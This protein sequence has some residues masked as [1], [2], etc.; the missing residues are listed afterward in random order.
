MP[1]IDGVV[2]DVWS[3][4]TE[5]SI[6][7]TVAGS[8]PSSPADCS[9]TWRGLWN[10]EYMY[11]LVVVN[12][13]TLN[14]D[15]GAGTK[16]EDDSVEFYIDGDNSKAA[17][18]DENDHQYTFRWN[19]ATVEA[20]SAIHNG[21]PSLA[22]VEYVMATTDNGYIF[23]VR[24]PWTSIMA[25][26][27][28][29][30]PV[31]GIEVWINDDDD[32]GG[33]DSQLSWYGTSGDGWNTPS[34]W[35]TGLLVAGNKATNPTPA[36]GALHPDIY[37]SL[38]WLP[39]LSA[40][41]HNVYFGDNFDDVD[42]GTGGTF[43][44]NTENEYLIVGFVGYPHPE[45]LVPDTTYYWRVD[46]VN[47][48]DPNSPW[49]GDVWSFSIPPK[50]AYFP[51]PAD[52][53][54]F[55]DADVTLTWEP[56]FGARTHTVYFGDDFDTV[57]NA[58]GGTGIG[59]TEY[60]PGTLERE[61]V[62]Y[63]RV[64]ETDLFETH[65]GDVW[66]FRT[67]KA[68]GGVRGD[69]YSGMDFRTH[70]LTRIDPQINFNWGTGEPDP[71]VGPD[72][73]SVR[74]TGE[75]EAGYTE[76]YTFYTRVDDGVR[77]WVGG[78]QLVG[79]EAWTDQGATEYSG[80][81]DLVAQNT[82]SITMEYYENGGDAVAELRWS[83][84]ST[85]KQFIPQ[86]AFSPPVR[87]SGPSPRNGA[88]DAKM[89]PTLRWNPGD[90]AASHEVYFGTDQ[91]AVKNATTGSPEYK[92]TRTLGDESFEPGKLAW[93]STYYWRVDEVNNLHADSPWVGNVW[94]FKT[95][96]FLVV[97][98][99]EDYDVDNQI[100]WNWLDGLGY[101]D[102][103][104]VTHAGNGSGSEAGDPDTA[105]YTEETIRH[106]GSQSMPYWYNNSGST[107]KF[108][109][110]EA[111][112]TLTDT[113]D[114][115]EE[116]V[117]ALSLW[118]RGYPASVGSLVESP[119]GT[120]AMTGSGTDIAGQSD[121][122]HYAYKVLTGPGTIV[123]RVDSVENTNDW[124]KAGVMIRET[125]EA[126]SAHAF[127]F[128]TPGNGTVFEYRP[129]AGQNYVPNAGQVTGVT[130]PYWVRL[131]RDLAGNFT[132]SA[133]T[134]GS[135]WQGL[136]TAA[137]IQMSSN[138]YIGLALTSHDVALTCQAVFSNVTISGN[139]SGQWM[140]Q[141]IGIQ[142]NDPEPMYVAVANSTG[143]PAVVYHDNPNA[144]QADTW[145]EW[146][147]DLKEFQ[148]KGINLTDVDSIAIGF[149][150]R[151]NPQ[152]GGAGKMYFDDIRL[153]RSRCVPDKLT[154]VEADLNSDCV[155][156]YGDLEIMAGDWLAGDPGLAGDLNADETVDFKD[157]VVLAD[158]WLEE[159]S[160][161]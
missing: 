18:P 21:E 115:T 2:D 133:S 120:Y 45:G 103:Q 100:W 96:D 104:G 63:W 29:A 39:G 27:T 122:F 62:Y 11:V 161:P 34:M 97:D 4:S 111:A 38:G 17:S 66:S 33:R 149:G 59:P 135:T 68:G 32:G 85:P 37:A 148:D 1:V 154:L 48:L 95:G 117:K 6:N 30:G 20:P 146:N 28:A 124:A 16:W 137:S 65:R 43:C 58:T 93:D 24:I 86:A 141:D 112:L 23:E 118:F 64:D 41:S 107:G 3:Y 60:T 52:D 10:W 47:D 15:S 61:K 44:G 77:L 159:Q 50:K 132:A 102:D 80:T 108:N 152:A 9:G 54:K 127:A 72:G 46:E 92:G 19:N 99:M 56:G 42:A 98:N 55:V 126:G 73:F 78:K 153:Y 81:I 87:A 155:V 25:G 105:S 101:V 138:V 150:N 79:D 156:D 140:S 22:G 123:A 106:G 13:E 109:Y 147:I 136:G 134:D 71:A 12:D 76:T 36:N 142:S 31:V 94:S 53:A 119:P 131:D 70:R 82:Y 35:A 8:A 91:D 151:N 110:S 14:N 57:N 157:Y 125:L 90:Y 40:V 67:A 143:T 129:F 128:V 113:R 75:V 114:W 121:E 69:Y 116:Q 88:T 84:P 83:S 144:A 5:Q 49:K 139:V 158:Q 130:A 160:W 89:T 26:P 7:I 74:W 51:N 145:T